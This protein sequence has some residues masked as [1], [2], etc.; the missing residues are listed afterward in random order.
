MAGQLGLDPPT[1]L[2]CDEGPAVELQRALDN[3]E[4]VAKCFNCSISTSAIAMTIY[5]S[6]SLS[7]S[8]RLAIE[9]QKD[10]C[11]ADLKLQLNIGS[12][13]N[14]PVLNAPI[15]LYILVPDLPKR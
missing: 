5:C 10:V 15:I 2:L 12:R 7:S 13:S 8:D 14:M 1:M 4:A 9:D 3:S 6:I 11:L